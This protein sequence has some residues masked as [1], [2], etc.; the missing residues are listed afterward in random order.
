MDDMNQNM[1]LDTSAPQWIKLILTVI[2]G[3]TTV[4][5]WQKAENEGWRASI[6]VKTG[7]CV[8]ANVWCIWTDVFCLF[9]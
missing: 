9:L 5:S 4:D 6:L 8:Q 3:K 2:A 7:L 1:V